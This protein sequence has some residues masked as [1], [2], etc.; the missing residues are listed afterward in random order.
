[1]KTLTRPACNIVSFLFWLLPHVLFALHSNEILI[2]TNHTE[3][4][5]L[6]L[7]HYYAQKR[8]IPPAHILKV[9]IPNKETCNRVEYVTRIAIPIRKRLNEIGPSGEQIRCLVTMFGIPLRIVRSHRSPAP[10]KSETNNKIKNDTEA[11]LDSELMLVRKEEDYPV[12]GWIKNP[13]YVGFQNSTLDIGKKDVLMVARLD[14]PTPEIVKRVIDY[15][16][17]TEKTGLSGTAYF[18][19]RWPFSDKKGQS[20]YAAYDHSIHLAARELEKLRI[21]PVVLDDKNSLFGENTCPK[22]ALYC[23]WYS[24]ATYINAFDWMPG[25]IGYHI[26][27]SEC[28]TLKRHGSRVWCKAMLEKGI[29]ATLGPVGEPYVQA[30]PLPELFFHF[31]TEGYL[32]LAEVYTVTLPY[33]SW[34]MVLIGDPLYLPFKKNR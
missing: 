18:D 2:I 17:L 25:A 26:A 15:S 1:M 10:Q 4:K 22:A 31:L 9:A 28:T 19:A 34:K 16:I 20:A 29:A 27:S 11:S 21:M 8:N 32:T 12:G 13:Y 6:E 30:F 3:P 33:I 7:A 5:S 14:G 23:G 24:L